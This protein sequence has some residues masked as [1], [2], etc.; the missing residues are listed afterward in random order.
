MTGNIQ[1]TSITCKGGNGDHVNFDSSNN[2]VWRIYRDNVSTASYSPRYRV[3]NNSTP[4]SLFNGFFT[5]A[6]MPNTRIVISNNVGQFSTVLKSGE[7]GFFIWVAENSGASAPA[8]ATFINTGNDTVYC[9]MVKPSGWTGA[10]NASGTIVAQY[11]NAVT[12][13]IGIIIRW[14]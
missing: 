1:T 4:G 10:Y 3:S 8:Y 6:S 2:E 7:M 12:Y 11:S 5:L 13:G 14:L 9:N